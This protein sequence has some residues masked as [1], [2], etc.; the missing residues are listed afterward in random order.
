MINVF[1]CASVNTVDKETIVM[2]E[3]GYNVNAM[4]LSSL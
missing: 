3:P 1:Y 2:R 4:L